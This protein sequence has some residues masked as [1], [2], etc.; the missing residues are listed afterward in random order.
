MP[1]TVSLVADLRPVTR[2]VQQRV[3][4]RDADFVAMVKELKASDLLIANLETPL[5]KRGNPVPKFRNLRSDPEVIQ[6]VK[7]LGVHA[8]T[9][10]TT[11]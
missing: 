6:D 2:C 8:V 1:A 5:S 3:R 10:A 4:D 7:A 9:L 11:T